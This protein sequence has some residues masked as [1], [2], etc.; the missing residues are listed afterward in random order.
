[1]EQPAGMVLRPVYKLD[2]PVSCGP[3]GGAPMSN[4]QWVATVALIVALAALARS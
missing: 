3:A 1:M 2:P 4:W